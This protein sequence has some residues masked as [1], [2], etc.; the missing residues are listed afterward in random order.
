MGIATRL[1]NTG[2]LFI[3]G[4]LDE[5][6][7]MNIATNLL[8]NLDA[9]KVAN[10]ANNTSTWTDVGPNQYNFSFPNGITYTATN[11]G[12]YTFNGTTQYALATN[13]FAD[14]L[15]EITA[16]AWIKTSQATTNYP[17]IV[18]KC[19]NVASNP[20]WGLILFYDGATALRLM[21]FTQQNGSSYHA[22]Y[23]TSTIT[24]NG[25]WHYVAGTLTGGINGTIRLYQDGVEITNLTV[26]DS[27]TLTTISNTATVTVATDIPGTGNGFI[28]GN[29][30]DV[31]IYNRA[32]S[33]AEIL[34]NYNAK[35]ALFGLTPTLTAPI[36]R[37]STNTLYVNILDEVS[38]NV[39]S[40]SVTQG[41]F[42]K[43]GYIYTSSATLPWTALSGTFTVEFWINWTTLSN[44]VTNY[45]G[46][47]A[48][49]NGFTI[50]FDGTSIAPRL[51]G[52]TIGN[53]GTLIN[54]YNPAFIPNTVQ[55][56]HI[57]V[58]RNSSN[59]IIMYI[60]GVAQGTGTTY[61][62]D[63]TIGQWVV[64]NSVPAFSGTAG[65]YY[66]SGIRVSSSA[67]YTGAFS[68]PSSVPGLIPSTVFLMPTANSTNFLFDFKTGIKMT[69]L[70]ALVGSTPTFNSSS[71][72][73]SG[74]ANLIQRLLSNGTLQVKGLVQTSL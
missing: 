25:A 64:G 72:F 16:A 40:M 1:T 46:V 33:S 58:V 12:C 62:N 65:T 21:F 39:G 69:T 24:A 14:S 27:G 74:N 50:T 15:G 73:N 70:G 43:Y 9:S 60:N 54:S 41:G 34:N 4:K 22:R 3:N 66:M 48:Q 63:F 13:T 6:T 42:L 51:G 49:T 47:P 28:N 2:T 53:A 59:L 20:G 17:T 35:A 29:I 37:T 8:L 19:S 32:L 57:A 7:G 23:A 61:S 30:A 38:L 71:P 67:V 10:I 56:Y 26:H 68:P 31:Q 11:S 18:A 5:V 52:G 44:I 45:I 36:V 55:W